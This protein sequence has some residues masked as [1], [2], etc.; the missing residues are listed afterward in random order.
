MPSYQYHA[1]QQDG[2][3]TKGVLES[4]SISRARAA[5]R[6]Q[7][8]TLISIKA[9]SED[10]TG[11]GN[12]LLRFFEPTVGIK[13]ICL[14]TRQMAVLLQSG[15]PLE[16][17]IA[18]TAKQCR[19]NRLKA[20]MLKIRARI[21]EGQSMAQ[22]LNEHPKIFNNLYRALVNAGEK[23]GHLDKVLERLADYTES[24]QISQQQLKSAMTYPIM[25]MVVAVLVVGALM[26]FVVP[27]LVS[28]FEN[29]RTEL[30]GLTVALIKSSDF[31]STYWLHCLAVLIALIVTVQKLL[32]NPDRRRAVHAWTLRI[33][34]V[35]EVVRGLETARFASTLSILTQ[36]G[37][38]L[39]EALSIA[40]A[41]FNNMVLREIS[42]EIASEVSKGRSF[43]R[44]LESSGEFPPM[45]VQ[46]IA[47]GEA[48]GQLENMLER[49]ATNQERELQIGLDA[50]MSTFQPL[51][52]L[53]M[54]GLVLTIV[55]A[56]LLPMFALNDLVQ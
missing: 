52:V 47:S 14:V 51:M 13:D 56:V 18:A 6:K 33:P 24:R 35:G 49:S 40:Q 53:M 12:I 2:T 30:P 45:M 55:L 29:T 15:L 8:L 43:Y 23:A 20:V 34:F 16:E 38:P 32:T 42:I 31:M 4:D 27:K 21:V 26:S 54:A 19:R 22:A 41:V 17:T 36:S 3:Q 7:E 39:V 48:S 9:I 25:L 1:L 10:I 46:M 44:A 11:S 37:V 5:L 50:L 28:I